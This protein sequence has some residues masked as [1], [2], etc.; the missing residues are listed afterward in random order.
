MQP[1]RLAMFGRKQPQPT[2]TVTAARRPRKVPLTDTRQPTQPAAFD[3]NELITPE[4]EQSGTIAGATNPAPSSDEIS[5]S[6]STD[7]ETLPDVASSEAHPA[8][9]PD[10]A[11]D[12]GRDQSSAAPPAAQFDERDDVISVI[13]EL[14]D[15]LD[16]YEEIRAKLEQRLNEETQGRQAAEQTAQELE[17]RLLAMETKLEAAEQSRQE[18]AQLEEELKDAE[19]NAARLRE[20][21]TQAQAEQ[22]RLEQELRT[23]QKSLEEL[24]TLRKERDG[25]RSELKAARS[26]ADQLQRA[27]EESTQQRNTLAGSL[28]KATAQ[29]DEAQNQNRSLRGRLTTALEEK[30]ELERSVTNLS[31]KLATL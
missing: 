22:T 7:T 1:E 29:L 10:G 21:L 19:T 23:Q 28:Q 14:E 24:W 18:I 16:R 2:V 15:Q 20:Q 8:T 27:L 9:E 3:L 11:A 26:R 17:W 13:H 6:P 4:T 25:L 5:S 30:G 12:A 31:E